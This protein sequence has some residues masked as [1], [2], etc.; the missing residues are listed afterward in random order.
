MIELRMLDGPRGYFKLRLHSVD[1]A[2][3]L[4]VALRG[5]P[6]GIIFNATR[7]T[8]IIVKRGALFNL[9]IEKLAVTLGLCHPRFFVPKGAAVKGH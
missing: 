1:D 4:V 6:L 9:E 2:M 5:L 7:D 3:R 8:V